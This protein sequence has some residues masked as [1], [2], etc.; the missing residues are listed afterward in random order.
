MLLTFVIN[1][2]EIW[3]F[4][5]KVLVKWCFVV[6]GQS[7]RFWWSI[8]LDWIVCLFE[9]VH[10]TSKQSFIKEKCSQSINRT[11]NWSDNLIAI[12]IQPSAHGSGEKQKHMRDMLTRTV[13]KMIK[14]VK[15]LLQDIIVYFSK[16]LY[17]QVLWVFQ[18]AQI[19]H[20]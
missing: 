3:I 4:V 10:C 20:L 11:F 8:Q 5:K 18:W 15:F 19:A 1:L 2:M 12:H 7:T 14:T 6:F 9:P 16:N 13:T 17:R